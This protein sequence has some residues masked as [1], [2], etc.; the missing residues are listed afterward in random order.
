MRPF[1]GAIASR[2]HGDRE[3][4][5]R[6]FY[7]FYGTSWFCLEPIP[8]QRFPVGQEAGTTGWPFA[9]RLAALFGPLHPMALQ[10]GWRVYQK[11]LFS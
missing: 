4:V 1:L 6:V 2:R 5:K 10:S 3:D 11:V 8:G 7:S 9:E